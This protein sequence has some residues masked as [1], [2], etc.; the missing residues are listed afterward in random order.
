MTQKF[1]PNHLKQYIVNQDY[2]KYTYIDHAVWRYIMKIN[3]DFFTRHG[4]ESYIEG[5]DKTGISLNKIP[6]VEDMDEKLSKIGWGAV[7][8]R[9]FIHPQA[10][11]T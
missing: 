1:V 3:V 6:K 2:S 8:V 9:G 11:D 5:L 10:F 4:H 7:C